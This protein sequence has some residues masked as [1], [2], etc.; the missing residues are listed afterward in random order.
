MGNVLKFSGKHRDGEEPHLAGEAICLECRYEWV[1][2]AP[3]GDI[4]LECQRCGTY[5]GRFKYHSERD[6]E[7]WLCNCGNDLFYLM[8]EGLYCPRCGSWQHGWDD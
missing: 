1:G 3:V 2:V 5:K 6:G 4:W 7:H 8:R